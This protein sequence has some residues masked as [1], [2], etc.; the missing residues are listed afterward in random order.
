MDGSVKGRA[1]HFLRGIAVPLIAGAILLCPCLPAGC[2]SSPD[3][4]GKTEL[5]APKKKKKPKKPKKKKTGQ[6]A[7]TQEKA[8]SG[9]NGKVPAPG[10]SGEAPAPGNPEEPPAEPTPPS[11]GA[12]P[13]A[14]PEAWRFPTG[15]RLAFQ[16]TVDQ[17]GERGGEVRERFRV[18]G[19]T[20]L[21]CAGRRGDLSCVVRE[22]PA[23]LEE[24]TGGNLRERRSGKDVEFLLLD[25]SGRV[26]RSGG[27]R[28][29][30]LWRGMAEPVFPGGAVPPEG[31]WA[32]E[33]D[34][35]EGRFVFDYKVEGE[36]EVEGRRCLSIRLD[37]RLPGGVPCDAVRLL[38]GR[39]HILFDP[40]A[41]RPVKSTGSFRLVFPEEEGDLA[42][43]CTFALVS[44]GAAAMNLGE[45]GDA[46]KA[47]RA[48]F[49]V[50]DL[51]DKKSYAAAEK[52]IDAAVDEASA[53]AYVDVLEALRER[54]PD[55]R[56]FRP[57]GLLP[58]VRFDFGGLGWVRKEG[59]PIYLTGTGRM[60]PGKVRTLACVGKKAPAPWWKGFYRGP[61]WESVRENYANRVLLLHVWMSWIPPCAES[62]P[63]CGELAKKFPS[64]RVAVLGISM[65]TE[66]KALNGFLGKV[67]FDHPTV[68][69]RDNDAQK[70]FAL[71]GAPAFLVVDA[72]GI[73]RLGEVGWFGERTLERLT[74]AI[75]ASLK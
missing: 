69:D 53:A 75:R 49:D 48:V 22:N 60:K 38:S 59:P 57:E 24:R 64:D 32:G 17:K 65:D 47:H 43:S 7:P 16:V 35:R 45:A 46:E 73:V 67:K 30:W 4:N 61:R 44:H 13:A 15:Q 29:S 50:L 72:A 33:R 21:R 27:R 20:F 6:T 71:P 1:L 5:P 70:K 37:V 54:I 11:P 18:D 9:E 25:S 3:G 74:E 40:A 55:T 66:Q 52:R 36:Q 68:W 28:T 19:W 58:R 34:F 63:R 39:G 51:I 23:P 31:T 14:S 42:V 2:G 26:V 56:T 10:D 41:G 8:P 62:V 12:S